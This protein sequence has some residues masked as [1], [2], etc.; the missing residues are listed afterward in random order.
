MIGLEAGCVSSAK[1]TELKRENEEL[2]KQLKDLQDEVTS[3]ENRIRQVEQVIGIKPPTPKVIKGEIRAVSPTHNIVILNVGSN[4]GVEVGMEFK[5][6]RG[7]K[8]ISVVRVDKVD[9]QFSSAILL[10]TK[11]RP[12]EGDTVTTLTH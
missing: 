2:T 10:D 11:G 1:Y 7:D 5:V 12:E 9:E 3:L 6:C 8:Y 4:D